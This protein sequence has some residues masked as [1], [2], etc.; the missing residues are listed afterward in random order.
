MPDAVHPS[1]VSRVFARWRIKLLMFVVLVP[2]F[3]FCYV[4]PQWVPLRTPATLP[5]TRVDRAVPFR[6]AWVYAYL[7]LY[8]MLIF[9]PLFADRAEQLVRYTV[10]AAVMFGTATLVFFAWPVRYPRPPLPD[11]PPGVYRLLT[12]IDQ[13][14]N[15]IPSLHAG[16]V[17]YTLFFAAR[18]FGEL[19]PGVRGTLLTVGVVWGAVILY[20]TLATKQHYLADL[21]PGALLGWVAH[22][23][24]WRGATTRAPDR[25]GSM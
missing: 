11:V 17:A 24:A 18:T 14:V 1:L 2:V 23:V 7:S 13:P 16:L 25:T 3:E 15:S 4:L 10:G 20:A 9:P 21:P 5:L 8:L 12:T 6:P 19:R 22:R